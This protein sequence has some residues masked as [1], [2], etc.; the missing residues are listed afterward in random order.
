MN[1]V[2]GK[3]RSNLTAVGDPAESEA[4]HLVSRAR[5]M[6]MISGLTTVLA[7]AAVV[8]VIGYRMY[9][10]AGGAPIEDSITLPK[11]ARVVSM[12]G[13]GGRVAVMIDNG[14]VSE[15]RVFDLK[16]MKESGHLRFVNEP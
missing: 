12:A 10:G 4:A 6:M 5:T 13:S 2:S 3:A 11:G 9:G 7:I 1:N 16:T 15:M 8:T 14:G